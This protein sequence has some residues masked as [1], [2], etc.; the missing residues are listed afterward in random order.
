[1]MRLPELIHDQPMVFNEQ[2]NT[3]LEQ[4][5]GRSLEQLLTPIGDSHVGDSVRH[6]GVYAKIKE[7]RREDDASLPQGVWTHELKTADWEKVE[8][9]ALEALCFKSKDLQLGVWLME[10]SIHR[11]GFAGIAPAAVLLRALCETFWD[12]MHPQMLDGDIEFR[13]NPINW[14]NQKLSLCLRLLPITH[15]P[16]DGKEYTW[17]DWEN[18][19]RYE[20]LQRQHQGQIKWEGVNT[21]LF[22]QR[23]AATDEIFLQQLCLD[24]FDANQAIDDLI[25]W[26][27]QQCE[28]DSPSLNE[29]TR[30]MG[31]IASVAENELHRRGLHVNAI[32]HE[33][34]VVDEHSEQQAAANSDAQNS[35]DSGEGNS[36]GA[37]SGDDAP[38]NNGVIRN[39]ADAFARLREAATFL[40]KDDPHSPVPYMVNTACQWGEKSAPDLYQELF[41]HKA[42]QLNIF[43]IMGLSDKEKNE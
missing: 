23:L 12:T 9:T 29:M 38:P 20:Q 4:R 6:N 32:A 41:L 11:Y 1:M 31:D 7:A 17:D 42:G 43:E 10:S 14:M 34:A 5:F 13:T 16:L 30:L 25:A 33:L 37:G 8:F 39:R 26:F 2:V 15:T 40:M 27:D 22:R 24:I 28:H 3:Y 19:Q 18:A 35:D 36:G 21:E